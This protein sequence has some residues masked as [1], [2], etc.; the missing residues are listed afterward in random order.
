M[1]TFCKCTL[2]YLATSLLG[3]RWGSSAE[4]RAVIRYMARVSVKIVLLS[5]V[6]VFRA[7]L[8]SA[9]SFIGENFCHKLCKAQGL[10]IILADCKVLK[11]S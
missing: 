11:N 7:I 1:V 8:A 3:A 9:S 10:T 2:I 5:L 4:M 6:R